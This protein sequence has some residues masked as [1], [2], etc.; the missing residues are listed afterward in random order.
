MCPV[1]SGVLD[2]T[3]ELGSP[4]VGQMRSA[5]LVLLGRLG[6]D[7]DLCDVVQC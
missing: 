5:I 4:G 6:D 3:P 1:I 2:F 7:R